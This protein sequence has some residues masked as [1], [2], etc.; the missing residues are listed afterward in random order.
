MKSG[1]RSLASKAAARATECH[2]ET[3][4]GTDPAPAD[5]KN[6]TSSRQQPKDNMLYVNCLKFNLKKSINSW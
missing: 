3:V 5:T 2:Q 4:T 1:G 6:C